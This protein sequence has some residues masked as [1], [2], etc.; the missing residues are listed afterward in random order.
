MNTG[1]FFDRCAPIGESGCWVWL[2][3]VT[4]DGYGRTTDGGQMKYAHRLSYEKAIGPI[5]GGMCVCH[6]CDVRCCVNPDH[7][8][9]GTRAE[10]A[11]DR[12]RKGRQSRKGNGGHLK[13]SRGTVR[14]IFLAEGSQ[15]K[16]A[17][18]F[19]VTQSFVSLVRA[20]KTRRA[21]TKDLARGQ[22]RSRT[23]SGNL[24]PQSA[25][26]PSRAAKGKPQ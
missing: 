25:S 19:G 21:D 20:Q 9:L 5:P 22:M 17:A 10:N 8:W 11:T 23:H 2:G 15:A 14:A 13:F 18:E 24:M 1:D 3:Y 16:I 7:L 12:D 26:E 4:K 6:K